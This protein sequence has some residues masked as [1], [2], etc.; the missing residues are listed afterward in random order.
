[1]NP[2]LLNQVEEMIRVDGLQSTSGLEPIQG[3]KEHLTY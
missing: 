2:Y 3:R 1:M